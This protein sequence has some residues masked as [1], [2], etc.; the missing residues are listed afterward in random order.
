MTSLRLYFFPFEETFSRKCLIVV[1]V[2]SEAGGGGGWSRGVV[3]Y[4]LS[5]FI[6]NPTS[7]IV[8]TISELEF[9]IY[10]PH[11]GLDLLT[12]G[13][14][15]H[16]IALLKCDKFFLYRPIIFKLKNFTTLRLRYDALSSPARTKRPL[17]RLRL[18]EHNCFWG[19]CPQ[20]DAIRVILPYI[21]MG[22][23]KYVLFHAV[24]FQ[25]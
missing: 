14:F 5:F 3:T 18:R 6:H 2:P 21:D 1:G 12:P 4:E 9:S 10:F 25:E 13:I 16:G 24:I 8:R 23:L 20:S 15:A 17:R 7:E 22:A 11:P 19:A